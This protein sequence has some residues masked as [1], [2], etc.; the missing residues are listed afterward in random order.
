MC[1]LRVSVLYVL[2]VILI[3]MRESLI[4][5]ICQVKLLEDGVDLMFLMLQDPLSVQHSRSQQEAQQS[6][7]DVYYVH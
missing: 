5:L 7:Q 3:L 2:I 1:M 4:K 6:Q